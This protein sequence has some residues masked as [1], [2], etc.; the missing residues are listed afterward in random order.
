MLAILEY[1][2]VNGEEKPI[3]MYV[4]EGLVEEKV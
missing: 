3:M 1:R 4:K 2:D